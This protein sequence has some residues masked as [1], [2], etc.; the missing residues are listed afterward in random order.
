MITLRKITLENRRA[1]F[2]LEV[3]EDQRRFVASYLPSV[4]SCYVLLSNG[5]WNISH[6]PGG[7]G[8]VLLDPI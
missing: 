1:M 6:L 7:A 2:R 8:R 3:A 5:Y 4:A